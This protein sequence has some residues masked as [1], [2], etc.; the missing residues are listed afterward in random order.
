[1]GGLGR[2]SLLLAGVGASAGAWALP[3]SLRVPYL[4]DGI[5]LDQ[6]YPAQLLRRAF[7]AG[8]QP[9]RLTPAAAA[10]PQSRALL[11]LGR[12]E[13]GLDVLW[14]QTSAAREAAAHPIRVPIDKGLVGWRLLLARPAVA[15]RLATVRS[16]AELKA[17][18]LVHGLDWPDTQVLKD[19]GL[20]V[21]T[22]GNFEAMYTQL[23]RGRVD[24][25][26]RAV[27]EIWREAKRFE[28][29]LVV[30]PEIALRY[31]AAVYFFVAH[32][33]PDLANALELGL[34]RL[35]ASGE[36]DRILLSHHQ[37]DLQRAQLPSRHVLSLRN[38]GLPPLTPI[39]RPDLWYQPG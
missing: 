16:L 32:E 2:R 11:T 20:R 21:A 22:S 10:L 1:M 37:A 17:F 4:G 8:G 28:G 26:P 31:Q 19:A 24:A 38:D 25:F 18:R 29:E 27:A 35:M 15:A 3:M 36:F 39:D 14:C 9:V 33:R 6:S 5:A 7:E 30:V 13:A 12:T 23:R 34:Q